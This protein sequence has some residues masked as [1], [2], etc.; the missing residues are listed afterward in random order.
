MGKILIELERHD[1]ELS[2]KMGNWASYNQVWIVIETG[3]RIAK[4]DGPIINGIA[5]FLGNDILLK[6]EFLINTKNSHTIM[7]HTI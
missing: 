5:S 3:E 1:V 7:V 4:T 2:L 6:K